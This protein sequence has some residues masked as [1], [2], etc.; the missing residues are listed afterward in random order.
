MGE[1]SAHFSD[2]LTMIPRGPRS[3]S[4]KASTDIDSS[5]SDEAHEVRDSSSNAGSFTSLYDVPDVV[6][7]GRSGEKRYPIELRYLTEQEKIELTETELPESVNGHRGS[8][9]SGHRQSDTLRSAQRRRKRPERGGRGV[10]GGGRSQG[11]SIVGA[12]G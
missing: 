9:T 2:C 8:D 10:S 1:K 3:L 6:Q 11:P 4:W 5:K 12:L 7:L